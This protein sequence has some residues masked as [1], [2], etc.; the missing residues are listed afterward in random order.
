MVRTKK[1]MRP[2]I[3]VNVSIK[4]REDGRKEDV[5]FQKNTEIFRALD[6]LDIANQYKGN[7]HEMVIKVNGIVMTPDVKFGDIKKLLNDHES[8]EKDDSDDSNRSTI[9]IEFDL[10]EPFLIDL[11]FEN[12]PDGLD[13]FVVVSD[14]LIQTRFSMSPNITSFFINTQPE[15]IP[16]SINDKVCDLWYKMPDEIHQVYEDMNELVEE[17]TMIDIEKRKGINVKK[18]NMNK[19]FK[20][21]GC[22]ATKRYTVC[23]TPGEKIASVLMCV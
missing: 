6:V 21:F 2:R 7:G 10:G 9:E 14:A 20:D 8:S 19:T 13:D 17:M 12:V 23:I 22:R 3:S 15:G 18:K 1:K 5:S 4:G 11:D 16:M